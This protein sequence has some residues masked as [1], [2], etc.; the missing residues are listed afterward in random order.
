MLSTSATAAFSFI[1]CREREA[2][3]HVALSDKSCRED[4]LSTRYI[5]HQHGHT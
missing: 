2:A 3:A 1:N 4:A 5:C